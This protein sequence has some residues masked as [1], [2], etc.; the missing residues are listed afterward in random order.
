MYEAALK[1]AE[2]SGAGNDAIAK[3]YARLASLY[4]E[5]GM[6]SQSEVALGHAVTLLR[7]NA[8]SSSQLATNIN[9][10]GMLHAEMGKMREAEREELEALRLRQNA[11]DSLGIARSWN[12][13]SAFYFKERKY[14][15][16]RDLA[17]RALDEFSRDR[18][19]DVVDRISSRLN[20]S[21]ALCYM[22]ECPSAVPVLKDAIAISKIAFKPTDFPVGEGE[23]L[24]GFAYWKSGDVSGAR[25][26]MEEGTSMMKEQLGWGHPAYL[27]ALGQYARFLRENGRVEDAETVERQI[28]RAEAVVDVHSVQTRDGADSLAGLR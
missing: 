14:P 24:L 22:K 23:F 20:L 16:S 15:S 3:V 1:E 11:G 28:R 13:L 2:S 26:Y 6:Y 17:Q 7:L 12:A 21:L 5:A 25:E 10:L 19:A 27:S 8:E 9:Y 4:E 18:Q